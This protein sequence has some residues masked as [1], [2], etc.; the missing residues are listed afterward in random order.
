MPASSP[1]RVT[2]ALVISAER[3]FI[4]KFMEI[5]LSGERN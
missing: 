5:L 1:T 2:A 3:R 4:L